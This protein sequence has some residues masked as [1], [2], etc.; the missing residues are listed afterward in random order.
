MSKNNVLILG[1]GLFLGLGFD[2]LNSSRIVARFQDKKIFEKMWE[3]YFS[4][5]SESNH[6]LSIMDYFKKGKPIQNLDNEKWNYI[7]EKTNEFKKVMQEFDEFDSDYEAKFGSFIDIL[8]TDFESGLIDA[9]HFQFLYITTS[10]IILSVIFY[11]IEYKDKPKDYDFA[12][13]QINVFT[14]NYIPSSRWSHENISDFKR[15]MLHGYIEPN[16]W[17][18]NFFEFL[19]S[20]KITDPNIAVESYKTLLALYDPSKYIEVERNI[21]VVFHDDKESS[22]QDSFNPYYETIDYFP[23]F[24]KNIEQKN[25]IN[26]VLSLS[27]GN[28]KFRNIKEIKEFLS[29]IHPTGNEELIA[30]KM[31]SYHKL[32]TDTKECYTFIYG[33][34][35]EN[36][37][38]LF[39]WISSTKIFVSYFVEDGASEDEVEVIV[40]RLKS[41]DPRIEPI[42]TQKMKSVI[43]A[44]DLLGNMTEFD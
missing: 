33:V 24:G 37:K 20:K 22:F 30:D 44:S 41:Y 7:K 39:H 13:H 18:I 5:T 21:K 8:L 31:F 23:L 15:R 34:N 25:R 4:V 9:N 32:L 40:E 17:N 11:E 28:L 6:E 19:N 2:S 16:I 26:L 14:F 42:T 29:K 1:N 35:I 38:E 43:E 3:H 12:C 36:H 27:S 10:L